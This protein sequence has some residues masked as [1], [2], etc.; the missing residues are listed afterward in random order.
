MR[1]RHEDA[2]ASEIGVAAARDDMS[3]PA[4]CQA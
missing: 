4:A 3:K 1:A 2:S